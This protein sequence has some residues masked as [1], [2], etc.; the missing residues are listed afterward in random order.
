MTTKSSLRARM[1]SRQYLP[2]PNGRPWSRSIPPTMAGACPAARPTTKHRPS[3][4]GPS[5]YAFTVRTWADTTAGS[6]RLRGLRLLRLDLGDQ[7]AIDL[8]GPL[9]GRAIGHP[10][11]IIDKG[12]PRFEQVELQ[13]E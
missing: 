7:L 13:H 8:L 4:P 9:I 12:R 11:G 1:C 5:C 3:G 6:C 10:P 2:R